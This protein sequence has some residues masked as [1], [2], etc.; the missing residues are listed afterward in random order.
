M[1]AFVYDTL[2]TW[3]PVCNSTL[4]H[5]HLIIHCQGM[6]SLLLFEPYGLLMC[7]LFT[8]FLYKN[9]E[10]V[11]K[12]RL[13]FY[14]FLYYYIYGFGVMKRRP[15]NLCVPYNQLFIYYLDDLLGTVVWY[16]SFQVRMVCKDLK[17][18]FH[19]ERLSSEEHLNPDDNEFQLSFVCITVLK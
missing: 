9:I 14:S 15:I 1:F 11:H 7:P 12:Y 5:Q 6:L 17:S 16:Y 8:H 10:E 2:H 3:G 18:P 19:D 13:E 4:W